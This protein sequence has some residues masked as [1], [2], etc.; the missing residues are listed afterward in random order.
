V[1]RAAIVFAGFAALL[2]VTTLVLALMDGKTLPLGLLGGAAVASLLTSA[3]LFA[4][5][6]RVPDTDPDVVRPVPDASY[7]TAVL[8]VG[9]CLVVFGF[10]FG[11]FMMLIGAGVALAGLAGLARE[12]I[13]LR[14]ERRRVEAA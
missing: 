8:A 2:G 4:A 10:V 1:R 13:A 5:G 3:G 7:A 11:S 14:R 6:S 9:I 12:Q